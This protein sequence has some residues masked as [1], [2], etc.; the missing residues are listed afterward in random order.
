MDNKFSIQFEAAKEYLLCG[1]PYW[2][3]D[4]SRPTD[5]EFADYLKSNGISVQYLVLELFEQVYIPPTCNFHRV[6]ATAKIRSDLR[7]EG[8]D[9]A[10]LPI[11]I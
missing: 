1:L 2:C 3:D 8:K 6:I 9:D 7:R 4:F 5:Q 10:E 11:Y